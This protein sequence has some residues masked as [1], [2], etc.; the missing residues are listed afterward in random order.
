MVR[1]LLPLKRCLS[2]PARQLPYAG[3]PPGI[4]PGCVVRARGQRLALHRERQHAG[5]VG[6]AELAR[7]T[8]TVA[9]TFVDPVRMVLVVLDDP[10]LAGDPSAARQLLLGLDGAVRARDATGD[11]PPVLLVMDNRS[12]LAYDIVADGDRPVVVTIASDDDWSLVGVMASTDIDARSAAASIGAR[13]LDA[14]VAP[15]A[16]TPA[17]GTDTSSRLAWR[18]PVR[19]RQARIAARAQSG[20]PLE[21]GEASAAK[22]AANRRGKPGKTAKNGARR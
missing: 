14:V 5:W 10:A 15:F 19:S 21:S 8:G 7:G 2:Q 16:A 18:G 11:R 6:G 22:P 13:G 3:W 1:I 20:R 12:V 9:T 4:G 17:A